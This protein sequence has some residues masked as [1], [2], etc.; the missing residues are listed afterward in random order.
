MTIIGGRA[1]D[2]KQIIEVG[3]LGFPFA[4]INIDDPET[5]A[6]HLDTLL[7]LKEKYG[8]FYLAHYP[9]EGDPSDVSQLE[10][11]FIPKMK[12]L[13]SLSR[14][15]GVQ[16]G[17]MHFWMDKRWAPAELIAAKTELL[18]E[19]VNHAADNK[20]VL[21]LENLTS[22]YDSFLD[23]F[24]AV[25]GLRMTMDIGHGELLSS[26]NTSFGFMAHLFDKI[27]H[28]HVHDNHGGTGVKDDLHLPLGEG[29]VDYPKILGALNSKGYDSTITLEVQPPDMTRTR[30]EVERYIQPS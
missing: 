1:H 25:P 4:E 5:V 28:I 12:K 29:V 19:L 22:Q 23:I 15:L 24:N 11:R 7:E 27:E 2:I 20:M 3:E 10:Q 9:N 18:A 26:E 13:I 21:C 8:F 14:D 16:K 17:T 30:K 6:G